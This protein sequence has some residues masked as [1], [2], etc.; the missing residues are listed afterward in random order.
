[1]YFRNIVTAFLLV[2]IIIF[3]GCGTTHHFL[4]SRPLDNEDWMISLA[5]HYDLNGL[6]K[7]ARNIIPDINAYIGI[8]KNYNFGFGARFPFFITRA[9]LVKYLDVKIDNNWATYIHMNEI[10]GNNNNPFFE[11]GGAR[12]WRNGSTYHNIS[13]G[14]GY[15]Q[16]HAWFPN[17]GTERITWIV[18]PTLKYRITGS[19]VGMSL[20]HYNGQTKSSVVSALKGILSDND[21]LYIFESGELDSISISKINDFMWREKITFHSSK[22]KLITA[23]Y[24]FYPPDNFYS[25]LNEIQY[26]LGDEYKACYFENDW[27]NLVILDLN[28]LNNDL[29]SGRRIIITRYPEKLVNRVKNLN[30]LMNDNSF[31]FGVFS[32]PE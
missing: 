3:S 30:S 7:P 24:G 19:D 18:L 21:N 12:N 13:L 15:G 14:I 11:I 8:G 1:M 25:S 17:I 16:Q 22:S 26:W 28:K 4:P 29:R 5:W 2:P 10:F 20:I 9:S 27:N 23:F 6:H 31:G 32:Y